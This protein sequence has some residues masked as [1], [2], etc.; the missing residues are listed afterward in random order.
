MHCGQKQNCQKW[1][2][3]WKEYKKA[4]LIESKNSLRLWGLQQQKLSRIFGRQGEKQS[5]EVGRESD[6]DEGEIV[7][8]PFEKER[9]GLKEWLRSGEGAETG[10]FM[11]K[12]VGKKTNRRRMRRSKGKQ[13]GAYLEEI[14]KRARGKDRKRRKRRRESI[15]VNVH[16]QG[17]HRQAK[18]PRQNEEPIGKEGQRDIRSY[19]QREGGGADYG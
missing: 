8:D 18:G 11:D 5:R 16:N 17:R 7:P 10:E 4:R 2:D 14:E 6:D 15:V 19:F 13:I 12:T 1:R 9:G 3:T